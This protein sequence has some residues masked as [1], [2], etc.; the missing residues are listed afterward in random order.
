[1][2]ILL[3]STSHPE[4]A[5]LYKAFRESAHSVQ[6]VDDS[7]DGA[8]VAAHDPFDAVVALAMEPASQADLLSALPALSR[9]EHTPVIVALVRGLG[10]AERVQLLRAGADACLSPPYS[11]V[12]I[13]ER[14]A[15]LQRTATVPA[16]LQAAS[17]SQITVHLDAT[18]RE[19][20]AGVGRVGLTRREYQLLECLLRCV[21]APVPRDQL[22]RYAWSEKEE[23]DP[24]C[25]NLVVSRLRR[26]L[27]G[28]CPQVRIETV[29]RYGY[30]LST[31]A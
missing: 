3:I 30:Q 7:R 21:D 19:L 6:R 17:A 13:H 15:A 16:T 22:I 28:R 5:W 25:V 12:E 23:V 31:E 26:K 10:A 1:M 2:R 4:A 9:V 18:T 11:F 8:F 20:V 27:A 29:S 14:I 24:A